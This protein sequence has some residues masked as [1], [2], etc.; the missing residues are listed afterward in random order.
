MNK[1]GLAFESSVA[2]WP[3]AG[4]GLGVLSVRWTSAA[5]LVLATLAFVLQPA[6][7]LALALLLAWCRPQAGPHGLG[8][9]LL[10]GAMYLALVNVTKR[11]ESDLA[12]YLEAFEYAQHLDLGP[13]LLLNTREPLYYVSLYGLANLPGVDGRIYVFLSTLLPYLLFGTAVLRI[14]V[15]L[16]LERRSLLSLLLFL[17]FFGQLFSL[18]AHLFRQFL[19]ASLAML[20]LADHA[21]T[22]RR[23][24]GLALFGMMVHYS[25][26]PLMLLSLL[27]PLRRYSGVLS[28]LFH[29][30]T[31]MVI[32]G[33]AVQVAPL[34][35]D[36]PVL[37]MMFQR[38][39]SGEGAE[40]DPLTL[41]AL[42]TAAL[43]LVI[44]FYSL[45]RTSGSALG[46]Q[47]WSVLLCTVTVC[48]IVLVSS[49]QPTLSE[50]ATRYF[51]YLY[52]LIGLVLPFLMMRV[53]L[54][55]CAVHGLALLSVPLFFYKLAHG[56]WTFAPVSSLI[57]E[58]MW[59]LWS[60][61][62]SIFTN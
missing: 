59:M 24:W 50:I 12:T 22:S 37:G 6:Q 34:L 44:S 36:V 47:D 8:V 13:F 42:A 20:F 55:R 14:G 58:P 10:L 41:P 3:S 53:P 60:H 16:R 25:A 7:S 17:L 33:L 32:Y 49:A 35:L 51:F 21:V 5:L 15:A 54:S 1:V 38:I 52:F 46:A 62:S 30:V 27:Q 23:R 19:A 2:K 40:L 43:F 45:A 39:A 11:P 61:Q 56:E 18:S 28:V 29:M 9:V 26:M 48:V 4:A 31:L 57:F